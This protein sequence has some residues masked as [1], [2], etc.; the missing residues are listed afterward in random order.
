MDAHCGVTQCFVQG[1]AHGQCYLNVKHCTHY[2]RH[3]S[4]FHVL[5]ASSSVL[6]TSHTVLLVE[7]PIGTIR[8]LYLPHRISCQ[9]TSSCASVAVGMSPLIF[10]SLPYRSWFLYVIYLLM[11]ESMGT[12]TKCIDCAFLFISSFLRGQNMTCYFSHADRQ[13]EGSWNLKV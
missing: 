3:M 9:P 10:S 13:Q 1:P 7:S 5:K 12:T 6:P 11:N 4:I 2:V 8:G